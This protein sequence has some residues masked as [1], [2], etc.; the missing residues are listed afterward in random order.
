MESDQIKASPST[1]AKSKEDSTKMDSD[2]S[3]SSATT[4]ARSALEEMSK[5]DLIKKC[6]NILTIAQKAKKA[7]DDC[8]IE[9]QKLRQE[10]STSKEMV[11]ALMTQKVDMTQKLDQ[12]KTQMKKFND[13]DT[14]NESL[15]RQTQRLET[16]NDKLL[17]HLEV[18]EKQIGEMTEI[19]MDQ[20]MQLLG[21]LKG[22]I[23]ITSTTSGDPHNELQ[24]MLSISLEEVK[25]TRDL[26]NK[27]K[28][29]IEDYEAQLEVSNTKYTCLEMEIVKRNN[30]IEELKSKLKENVGEL[31][32]KDGKIEELGGMMDKINVQKLEILERENTLKR[33]NERLQYQASSGNGKLVDEKEGVMKELEETKEKLIKMNELYEKSVKEFEVNIKPKLGSRF[34]LSGLDTI[35]FLFRSI[36]E[37]KTCL[38]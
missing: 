6:K 5:E 17:N 29:Q 30:Q 24:N 22:D 14:E 13:L 1:V 36:N 20:R 33:E 25:T 16:E 7:K 3:E 19:G 9:N 10:I 11:E 2:Q 8:G 38:T 21:L 28:L 4:S 31:Q 35:T 27:L 15:K 32:S 23:T 12:L 26:N 18:M 34:K 37:P